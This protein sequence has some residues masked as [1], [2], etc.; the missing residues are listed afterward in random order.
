VTITGFASSFTAGLSLKAVS[1]S[2]SGA[3]FY[4]YL[5]CP[6][7]GIANGLFAMSSASVILGTGT[8]YQKVQL[9]GLRSF[10]SLGDQNYGF[11]ISIGIYLGA[12]AVT[13]AKVECCK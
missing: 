4:D 5:D 2:G 6:D 13:D 1:A 3:E 9:G 11:D 10:N 12:S 8:G 7:P